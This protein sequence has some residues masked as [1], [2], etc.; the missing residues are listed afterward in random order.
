LTRPG[1]IWST[2]KRI[3][4]TCNNQWAFSSPIDVFFDGGGGRMREK[5]GHP[6]NSLSRAFAR[7]GC[8]DNGLPGFGFETLAGSFCIRAVQ[9]T[10]P[11][12]LP[13][14]RQFATLPTWLRSLRSLCH[15]EREKTSF[16]SSIDVLFDGGGGR[17]REE[18][19][20]PANILSRAFARRGCSE[21]EI[22]LQSWCN[23]GR[24]AG[25]TGGRGHGCKG[26]M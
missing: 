23:C 13:N 18:S 9:N 1:C 21:N 6:A 17:M 10:P 26:G 5:S 22:L 7:R 2:G 12:E 3:Q 20:H 25:V 19:G 11:V 14:Y 24:R 4:D 16:S 15:V 8:S